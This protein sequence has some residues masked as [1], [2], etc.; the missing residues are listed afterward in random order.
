MS[1]VEVWQEPSRLWRWRYL[2]VLLAW[3]RR[4]GRGHADR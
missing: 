2:A 4:A 3:R 1:V